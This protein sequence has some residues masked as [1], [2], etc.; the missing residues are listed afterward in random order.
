MH[1]VSQNPEIVFHAVIDALDDHRMRTGRRE[2][3]IVA[4]H[5]EIAERDARLSELRDA[6]DR[7]G[8]PA[9]QGDSKK[10][11]RDLAN[12]IMMC[13]GGKFDDWFPEPSTLGSATDG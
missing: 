10:S 3:Q 8:P 2:D 11:V 5:N 6:V 4:L 1:E 7:A 13:V 12:V 9:S